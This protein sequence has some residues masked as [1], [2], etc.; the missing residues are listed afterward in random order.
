MT[1]SSEEILVPY[2]YIEAGVFDV[3]M[4]NYCITRKYYFS[5]TIHH[6]EIGDFAESR[7]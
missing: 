6:S 3:T 5:S 4:K 7:C 2:I 1:L